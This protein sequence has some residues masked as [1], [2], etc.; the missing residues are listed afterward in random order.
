MFF[1]AIHAST[2]PSMEATMHFGQFGCASLN[3]M[4]DAVQLCIRAQEG[5]RNQQRTLRAAPKGFS[6][7]LYGD[8]SCKGCAKERHVSDTQDPSFPQKSATQIFARLF[9]RNSL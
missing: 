4:E 8:S 6:A 7:L 3:R 2:S 1:D 9:R 5:A